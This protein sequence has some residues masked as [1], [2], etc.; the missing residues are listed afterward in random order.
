[1]CAILRQAPDLEFLTLFFE[2]APP[3]SFGDLGQRYFHDR[4]EAELLDAHHLHYNKYDTLHY[5]PAAIPPCLGSRVRQINLAHY[6]G[7]RAQRTLARFLLRNAPLLEKL[8]CEFAEGP[9]WI[10][11]KLMQEMEGWVLNDT[12][13]KVFY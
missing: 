13:S 3:E 10:Q 11:T 6:Q 7:G 9:M 2:T 4:K 1:M 5:A 8:Y 12:A